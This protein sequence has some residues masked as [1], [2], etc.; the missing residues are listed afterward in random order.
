MGAAPRPPG[1]EN[2][3]FEK[4]TDIAEGHPGP[5]VTLERAI[6]RITDSNWVN[7]C[8]TFAG[9]LDSGGRRAGID[10]IHRVGN[11]YDFIELKVAANTPLHAAMEILQYGVIYVFSRI[12]AVP[13]GYSDESLKLLRAKRVHLRVLAPSNYFPEA[14]RPWLCRLER[15]ICGC[16][17]G[18]AGTMPL[19][20]VTMDFAFQSFPEEFAWNPEDIDNE[21]CLK[22]LLRAL[23]RRESLTA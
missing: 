5:E 15:A 23:H 2:W 6:I 16:L 4:R 11:E 14:F 9:L 20:G 18:F 10:L 1:A 22:N 7:Q 17:S 19:L 21:E 13:L 8:P 3:R 12:H